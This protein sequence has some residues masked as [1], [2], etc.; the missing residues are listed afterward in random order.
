V[1]SRHSEPVEFSET[2]SQST[3]GWAD[4]PDP[5]KK[6]KDDKSYDYKK[7]CLVHGNNILKG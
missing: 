3:E 5:G 2:L 1:E 6:E 4:N 7:G